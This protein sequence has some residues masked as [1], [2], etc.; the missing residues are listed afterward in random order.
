MIDFTF[1][2]YYTFEKAPIFAFFVAYVCIAKGHY[3]ILIGCRIVARTYRAYQCIS[4][5][6]K[7]TEISPQATVTIA[8]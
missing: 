4:M 7:T 6:K 8:K 3:D 2:S 1:I 5:F